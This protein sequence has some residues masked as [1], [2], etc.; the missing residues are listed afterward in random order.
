LDTAAGGGC[1]L[2]KAARRS[3]YESTQSSHHGR[4]DLGFLFLCQE[5]IEPALKASFITGC[6]LIKVHIVLL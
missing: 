6:F 3:S 1:S 4:L 2:V 5:L